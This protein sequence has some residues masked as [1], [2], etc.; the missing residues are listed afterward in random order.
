MRKYGKPKGSAFSQQRAV[1]M[2]CA[3]EITWQDLVDESF[4]GSKLKGSY[5][6]RVFTAQKNLQKRSEDDEHP[7]HAKD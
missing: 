6:E 5:L 3:S 1:S 4:A 7:R 2:V